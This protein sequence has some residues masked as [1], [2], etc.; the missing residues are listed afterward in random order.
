V[1]KSNIA[2]LLLL[3]TSALA[4][5]AAAPAPANPFKNAD[6]T[7]RV[8]ASDAAMRQAYMPA[9][10]NTSHAANL[11]VLKSGDLGLI[12]MSGDTATHQ[13]LLL[14]FLRK[15]SA[16]WSK[17][18]VFPGDPKASYENPVIFQDPTGDL[19]VFATVEERVLAWT[20]KD[21]GK[22]WGPST[23]LFGEK[24]VTRQPVKVL[25]DG[26]WALSVYYA[27]TPGAVLGSES[28]YS[29]VELSSDHGKSWRECLVPESGCRPRLSH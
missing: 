20:S 3:G 25:D 24:A 19:W 17:P 10:Y 29:A 13:V 6:G 2:V 21:S 22:T 27:P 1:T 23:A 12:W 8:S 14:S 16:V 18:T 4:Q 5:T 26:K 28:H 9:L 11:T 15:N 7:M